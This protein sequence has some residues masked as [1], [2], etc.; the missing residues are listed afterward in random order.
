MS[1]ND[2]SFIWQCIQ[3]MI[4]HLI[5]LVI[6]EIRNRKESNGNGGSSKNRHF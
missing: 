2:Y 3:G 5:S 1:G 4:I 6:S